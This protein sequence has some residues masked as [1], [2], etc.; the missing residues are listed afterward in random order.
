APTGPIEE[1]A[2]EPAATATEP[3]PPAADNG[4]PTTLAELEK[5]HILNTLAQCDGNRT[6]TAETLDINIRTLRN[7]LNEYKEQGADID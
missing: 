6:R 7:K 5:Q 3:T 4:T 1:V 2:P